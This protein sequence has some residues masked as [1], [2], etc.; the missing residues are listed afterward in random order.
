MVDF[1]LDADKK[2]GLVR[3]AAAEDLD[4]EDAVAATIHFLSRT[5]LQRGA[6][7]SLLKFRESSY[8]TIQSKGEL[9]S[10]GSEQYG[11]SKQGSKSEQKVKDHVE[12]ML[13]SH[14]QQ[15]PKGTVGKQPEDCKKLKP[16]R[17][18]PYVISLVVS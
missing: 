16:A 8:N 17:E 9:Q 2:Q 12:T 1:T 7:D 18:E 11:N 3:L 15:S 10:G 6:A 14:Q 4:E 5:F 13:C